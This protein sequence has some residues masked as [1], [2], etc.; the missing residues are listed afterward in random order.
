VDLKCDADIAFARISRGSR[1]AFTARVLRSIE[2]PGEAEIHEQKHR[3]IRKTWQAFIGSCI[4]RF[5]TA[6]EGWEGMLVP[7]TWSL[8]QQRTSRIET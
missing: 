2:R 8:E 7:Q 5:V 4:D 1:D 6:A 3:R